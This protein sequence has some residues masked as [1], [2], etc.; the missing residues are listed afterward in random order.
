MSAAR[1]D[2][3]MSQREVVLVKELVRVD[4]ARLRITDED[5]ERL[6]VEWTTRPSG[7]VHIGF[8]SRRQV[9]ELLW[10]EPLA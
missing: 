4:P 6:F 3:R 9:S 7:P 10:P 5:T 8:L 2:Q 1:E